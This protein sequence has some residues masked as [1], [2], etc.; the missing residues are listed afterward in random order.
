MLLSALARLPYRVVA[1]FKIN[2]PFKGEFKLTGDRSSGDAKSDAGGEKKKR[3]A[4]FFFFFSFEN[5]RRLSS[6]AQRTVATAAGTSRPR[7]P[8]YLGRGLSSKPSHLSAPPPSTPPPPCGPVGVEQH[9]QN[10]LSM[11]WRCHT[12][13]SCLQDLG[14]GTCVHSSF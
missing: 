11:F 7:P 13:T 3:R 10:R 8:G 1:G 4:D 9:F 14:G 2:K 5:H 12:A 6:A